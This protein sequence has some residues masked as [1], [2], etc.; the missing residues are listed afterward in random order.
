MLAYT[1]E[2]PT[3]LSE[4]YFQISMNRIAALIDDLVRLVDGDLK[5]A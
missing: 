1:E 3:D 5:L 4:A 2:S